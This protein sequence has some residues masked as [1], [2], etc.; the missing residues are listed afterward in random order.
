MLGLTGIVCLDETKL[1]EGATGFG[2]TGGRTWEGT[3]ALTGNRDLGASGGGDAKKGTQVSRRK[4]PKSFSDSASSL[5]VAMLD[6]QPWR[7]K[8]STRVTALSQ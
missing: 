1:G 6:S 7:E 3:G 2:G 4:W 8:P 5:V